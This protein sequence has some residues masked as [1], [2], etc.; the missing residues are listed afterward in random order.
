[1]LYQARKKCLKCHATTDQ[2]KIGPDT[3]PFAIKQRKVVAR[4]MSTEAKKQ[5]E[6]FLKVLIKFS[7]M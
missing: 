1:M 3:M 7:R 5:I 2:K 4:A 6:A